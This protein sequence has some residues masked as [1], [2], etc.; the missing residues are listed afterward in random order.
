MKKKHIAL[1]ISM[2]FLLQSIIIPVLV[3]GY[4]ILPMLRY[5]AAEPEWKTYA[6]FPIGEVVLDEPDVTEDVQF[7]QFG[8]F[9]SFPGQQQAVILRDNEYGKSFSI[10]DNST[11]ILMNNLGNYSE[12]NTSIE[13][14]HLGSSMEASI[15]KAA[16][17]EIDN[18][19][20][21]RLA[22]L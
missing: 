16:G 19:F 4:S 6:D 10:G 5:V 1:I 18:S 17:R 9:I 7:K 8:F 3:A 13:S 2:A 20:D 15:S 12:A 11:I 21:L 14:F 22:E